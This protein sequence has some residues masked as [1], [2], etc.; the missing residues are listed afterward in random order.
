MSS[1]R[2]RFARGDLPPAALRIDVRPD[3]DRV[4]VRPVGEVDLETAPAVH[5]VAVELVEKGFARVVID[6]SEVTFLDST[7]VRLLL[8]THRRACELGIGLSVIPGGPKT[9]R[10]LEV[11]GALDRL[12]LEDDGIPAPPG[13]GT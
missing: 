10:V 11:C 7:G 8:S 2:R 5:S 3:R 4:F 1:E 9:L 6:L 12:D 13:A